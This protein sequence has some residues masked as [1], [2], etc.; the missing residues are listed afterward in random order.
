V[1]MSLME[2]FSILETV[3]ASNS[4]PN[5]GSFCFIQHLPSVLPSYS[6]ATG[7][8]P[9]FSLR[10]I[11]YTG[12]WMICCCIRNAVPMVGWPAK[13][14]SDAGVNIR[15]S[16]PPSRGESDGRNVVSEKFVS[17]AMSCISLLLSPSASLTTAS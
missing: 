14:S 4:A 7:I 6:K 9:I 3:I 5:T 12:F 15:K 8:G 16:Y 13:G 2:T 10:T 11:F 1:S 17:R